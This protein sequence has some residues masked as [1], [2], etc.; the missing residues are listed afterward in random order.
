MKVLLAIWLICAG[1]GA[2]YS[3]ISERKKQVKYLETMEQGYQKLAYYM[4]QWRM[5]VEEAIGQMIKENVGFS[6][7]YKQIH[8]QIKNRSVN[9]FGVLWKEESKKLLSEVRL[10]E[11]LKSIWT[12][13]FLHMPL[14]SEAVKQQF[15]LKRELLFEKRKALEAKYKG[16]QR[17]VFSMGFFVSAFLCLILW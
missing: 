3:V 15:H 5:P 9:D 16:E 1:I 7:F 12:D 13:C 2:S 8:E 11:E 17:L 6:D 10:P 14:D 4:C